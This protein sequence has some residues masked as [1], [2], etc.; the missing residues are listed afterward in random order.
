MNAFWVD[1][2][3]LRFFVF[4]L[5]MPVSVMAAESVSKT[6]AIDSDGLVRVENVAGEIVITTWDR[7]EVSV[8]A[9]LGDEVESL[10]VTET[11]N[12]V[13]VRVKN[14]STSYNM[15]GSDLELKVPATANLEVESVSAEISVEGAG[16]EWVSLVSVSGD[17]ELAATV[18]R[19]EL[20]S[21]SGDVEYT[22]SS[23]RTQIESVSGEIA[24]SG[25]SGEVSVQTVSGEVSLTA[26]SI[27]R[28]R[29]EAV[30]GDL[31]LEVG[32]VASGRLNADNMSG[33]IN[34]SLPKD[35][36]LSISAQTFSGDIGSD[37][38]KANTS[39]HGPGSSLEFESPEG[40]ASL[41]LESFSGDI[42]IRRR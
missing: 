35:Q 33:D 20:Q 28:G 23:T 14:R 12:G 25:I 10:E 40:G 4:T 13:L 1:S 19:V 3:T 34:L 29:F 6:M 8:D 39:S 22:G 26:E 2:K 37:F 21:V 17:L 7:N 5:L 36:N 30:S 11:G 16:G 38:G 32:L 24:V 41:K 27:E 18:K 31:E 15:D 42:S 9:K